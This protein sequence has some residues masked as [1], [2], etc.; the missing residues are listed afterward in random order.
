MTH[1]M[2]TCNFTVFLQQYQYQF[3]IHLKHFF[4]II[5]AQQ[6]KYFS[7]IENSDYAERKK[8]R[9]RVNVFG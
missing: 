8:E 7:P 6:N 1:D 2:D 4:H 3:F 9:N 5:R